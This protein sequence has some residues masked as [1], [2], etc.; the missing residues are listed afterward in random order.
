MTRE[1]IS[2]LEDFFAN[3]PKQATPIYLNEATVI[4]NYDHFLES[5]FTPLRL[6][7]ESRV[8]QPLIWRLK[9]LKLIVEANL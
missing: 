8:N 9:A 2:Q 4:E 7:P 3:A 5:H 1:E 6:N